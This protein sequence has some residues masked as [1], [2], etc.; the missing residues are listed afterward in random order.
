MTCRVA[1]IEGVGAYIPP[2]IVT[3]AQLSEQLDTSDEW[4]R[5]MTGIQ[6]RNHNG[7]DSATSDLAA[8]AGRR[9]MAHAGG[10]AVDMVI[11]A[12]STPDFRCPATAPSVAAMIGLGTVPAFDVAAV[13]AGFVYALALGNS[14]IRSQMA[15]RVLVIGADS[16]T[17]IVDPNDRKTAVI[18]GDGAGAVVLGAADGNCGGILATDLGS[19]GSFAHLIRV[20]AGG[21]RAFSSSDPTMFDNPYFEMEGKQVFA[22]AVKAMTESSKRVLKGAE[23]SNDTVDHLI[24]HQANLRILNIVADNLGIS[25]DRAVLHLDKVGNTS[26]ASIPL[27]MAYAA[28][29]IQQGQRLLLT[30]FGG[31]TAWGS[32]ALTWSNNYALEGVSNVGDI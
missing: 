4:I 18:F 29:R 12:T 1:V 3:N 2:T 23:W 10:Q 13:C 7:V 30:A 21:A 28:P 6:S 8:E 26:A 19:D 17:S 24:A 5:R 27:A 16:F 15:D 31:G 20:P 25:R 9:A 11:L 14:V 32:V 22:E